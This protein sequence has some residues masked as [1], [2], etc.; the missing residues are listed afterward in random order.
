MITETTDILDPVVLNWLRM[1]VLSAKDI[2]ALVSNPDNVEA[3]VDALDTEADAIVELTVEVEALE[4]TLENVATD[5]DDLEVESEKQLDAMQEDLDA[6][7][8][9]I[10]A[11]AEALNEVAP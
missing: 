1:G 4:K 2:A 11:M 3:I 8:V 7:I 9:G 5:L 6:A 10:E